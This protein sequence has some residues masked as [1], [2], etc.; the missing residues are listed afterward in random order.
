MEEKTYTL[1]INGKPEGP[2]TLAALKEKNIKP[3]S[4]IRTAGMD[5]YKEAHELK[6]LRA[7][8]GFNESFTSPQ[9]FAGFDLRLLAT[10]IDWFILF[11]IAAFIELL[12]ALYFEQQ[13]TTL[14]IILMGAI[15]LPIIKMIYQIYMEHNHQATFGKKLLQIKV[16]NLQGLK[17]SLQQVVIRNLAKIISTVTVFFGYLYLFLNK[18]QQALHDKIAD[19]MVI[20][21]RLI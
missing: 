21:D 2:F 16:V 17:P 13:S 18:Q 5:D 14:F 10:V 4:F 12:L 8:F 6:E 20:K 7:F 3:D 9:Y 15:L 11:A 1:V 19:T